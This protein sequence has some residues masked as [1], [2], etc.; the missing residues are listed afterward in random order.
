MIKLRKASSQ[1]AATRARSCY[2]NKTMFSLYIFVGTK[3]LI[4]YV[5]GEPADG[6]YF[7]SFACFT[8]HQPHSNGN[9]QLRVRNAVV[10]EDG[11]LFDRGPA[12]TCATCHH[13]R[14]D[15]SEEV[16][17]DVELDSHYGP[18]HSNQADMI[19]GTNAYEYDGYQYTNSAHALAPEACVHCHMSASLHESVGG[20]SWNMRNEEHDWENIIG[21][22]AAECHDG[23]ITTLD[24]EAED[25][26]DGDGETEG[27]QTEIHGLL[28]ELTELL[29]AAN[30]IEEEIEEGDTA[31]APVEERVVSTADSAGAVYN[32]AFVEEDRSDGVHNT[33][34]TVGLLKSSINFL[35]T[36]DPN[37][38]PA[39]TKPSSIR[40]LVSA[41]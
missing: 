9:F 19:I 32:W 17:D 33:N 2:N 22:N 15:V 12:N 20:H 25:D 7:S 23:E 3:P 1:F 18:H 27:I 11:T 36:G 10:L 30:L 6:N 4:A 35:E 21:C 39:A 34:Y 31:Y 8:C 37:G 28:E 24:T 40:K 38:A 41:H 16:V 13:S 26:F 29:L 14:S 5:T